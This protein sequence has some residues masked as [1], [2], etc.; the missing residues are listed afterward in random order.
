MSIPMTIPMSIP[1][2]IPKIQS[3]IFSQFIVKKLHHDGDLN[4]QP[5]QFINYNKKHIGLY[6]TN[7]NHDKYMHF[8]YSQSVQFK[9][10]YNTVK[11]INKFDNK[12]YKIKNL[13]LLHPYPTCHWDDNTFKYC[14]EIYNELQKIKANILRLKIKEPVKISYWDTEL[15]P[16]SQYDLEFMV[17]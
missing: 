2:T 4:I 14:D 7:E 9:Y 12:L 6:F 3:S 10:I 11:P 17:Q 15:V 16:L 8:L 13:K 5:Q 1:M